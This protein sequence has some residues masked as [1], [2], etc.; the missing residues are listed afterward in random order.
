[1]KSFT[2]LWRY[3]TLSLVLIA[4]TSTSVLAQSRTISSLDVTTTD[5]YS[6][7]TT[8]DIHFDLNY[9]SPDSEWLVF[10]NMT[11]PSGVTVNS[12]S[13]ILGSSHHLNQNNIAG[14]VATWGDPSYGY[15]YGYLVAYDNPNS[16]T[17]NVTID[18]TFSGD[19]TINFYGHGD[20]WGGTPHD[21]SGQAVVAQAP[22]IGD[23]TGTVTSNGAPL[24]GATVDIENVAQ[25]T[26]DANGNYT[27]SGIAIG[28]TTVRAYMDGMNYAID[29][30][31]VLAGQTVTLDFNLSP[32]IMIIS[33]LSFTETLNPEEYLTD[34]QGIQNAGN[35]GL[36][37]TA[38]I[39]YPTTN[40]VKN[41][42]LPA[43]PDMTITTP[44]SQ[45]GELLTSPAT[46]SGSRVDCPSGTVFGNPA[47]NYTNAYT[48]DDGAGYQC[49]QS[50]SATD[51]FQTVTFYFV[52][53]PSVPATSDFNIDFYQAGSTP[54]AS[55][56]SYTA[57]VN[58]VNTGEIL[59]GSYP[60]YAFTVELPDVISTLDGW[61]SI[62][63]AA[64]SNTY[65]WVNT[66]TGNGS[67]MQGS[68]SLAEQLTVCLGAPASAQWLSLSQYEGYVPASGGSMSIGV[69]FDASG[70]TAGD[71][72]TA[73]I[74]YTANPNVSQTTVPVTMIIAGDPLI[75][76]DNL[77]ATLIDPVTGQVNLTWTF[78]PTMDPTFQ[79]FL[80]RRNGTPIANTT[81]TS[82]T[83]MLPT[84]GTYSYTVTAVYAEG[85][86]TPAGPVE[87]DWLIPQMCW[88]P[89]APYNAQWVETQEDVN[90]SISNCGQGVL[91]FSFPDYVT[92]KLLNDPTIKKNDVSP[93]AGFDNMAEPKKG[94]VDP[95]DGQG[96]PIVLGAGGPDT[97]GYEWIDSDET[98][99]PTFNWI[100][101]STIGNDEGL[102]GDDNYTT[103]SLPFAFPFYGNTYSSIK[104]STNGFL[105]FGN[106]ATAYSNSGIPNSSEPNN[107]ITA[108]WDDLNFTGAAKLFTY[109]DATN[110]YYV[111]EY[112]NVPKLGSSFVNTY[113][114]ILYPNGKIMFQY[115]SMTGTLNSATVGIENA[116]GSDGLQV[117]YNT[118]YIHDGLAVYIFTPDHFIVS[119]DPVT[120]QVSEGD[121]VNVTLTYSSVG[122]D[123]GD[124]TED[125]YCV[126]NELEP[127][128]EHMIGN[129]MH[130]YTPAT[131]YGTVTDCN[132]GAPMAGVD[133]TATGTTTYTATTDDNGYYEMNVD[134]DTYDVT[135]SLLGY[136]SATVSGVF[137]PEGVMTE[138]ST[139]MCEMPYPVSWVV[140]DPNQDDTQ[141]LVTWSLPMGPYEIIYDDGTAEEFVSWTAPGNAVAV[142][143][144]PAGYPATV[145]G[146]RL[147][148]GDGSFPA[149]ANFIG[150]QFAIG[151]LDDDGTN[152]MPGTVL[153]SI[154]VDVNNY[155]WVQFEGLNTTFTDGDF[156][157]VMWQLAN[158]PFAAPIG[159]DTQLPT[160]YRSYVKVGSNDWSVSPYQDFMMRAVVDGP[161]QGV[162]MSANA[163][164][165][166]IYPP[167]PNGYK[168]YIATGAPKGIPGM[169]KAGTFRPVV[170][171]ASTRDLSD[172]TV[173]YVNGFD[174]DAGQTPED[175]TINVITNTSNTSYNH[176]AWGGLPEGWYAYAVRANY[177]SGDHSDWT[178]SNVVGHLKDVAVT[179]TVQLCDGS[180]ASDATVTIVG[181]NYPYNTYTA[182]TDTTGIIV[183][184]S[185]IKG[186]YDLFVTK[187]GYQDFQ[188]MGRAIFA[189]YSEN[190]MLQKNAYPVR[191]LS[192]D[193][194]TSLATWDEPLITQL[195][196]QDFEDP[197]FP[198]DGWQ[199][200]TNG[201]GWFRTDDGG[202]ANFP[203][204]PGDGF[205]ACDNDDAAGTGPQSDGSMDYL[206]TP[207][208]DLRESDN[209]SLYF[210]QYFDGG[211]GELATVEY[212]LDD[213]ATWQPLQSMSPVTDWTP[214]TIDLS[215]FS[216]INGA[217]QIWFAFHAD[218]A[219]QWASGWAVDN[220]AV[221]NGAAPVTSYIVYLDDN[222]VIELP[223]DQLSYAFENLQ[224]GTTYTA[225][226]VATYGTFCAQSE[227]VYYT[228]TSSYLYPPR[229]LT[230]AYVYGTNEVPLLWNPPMT[231]DGI[232]MAASANY[233]K[234]GIGH[235]VINYGT[236]K[237]PLAVSRK[238]AH[239][240]I[241]S[242]SGS[243][244][245]GDV[246]SQFTPSGM[247]A[248]GICFDGTYLYATDPFGSS[249]NTIVQLNTDGS[250]TGYTIDANYGGS[251]IGDMSSDGTYIY[252]CNVGG[253]DA[254]KVIDIASGALV[255]T[256]TGDFATTSQ[257][258][259]AHDEI[260]D[261]FYIGGWNSNNIW[262]VD[263]TGATLDQHSESGVSGLAYHPQGGPNADGSLWVVDNAAS[264]PVNEYDINNGWTLLQNFTI[265]DGA[266]NSGAGLGLNGNGN[267]WLVNQSNNVVYEIETD[268]PLNGGSSS[269]VV[270]DGLISFNVYRDS[271][272]IANVPYNGESTDDTII[273]VDNNLMPGTYLYDVS[274][275]YDLS[276]FGFPG[277]TGE[278]AWE[279]TDTV[280]V[281]WGMNLPFFED[282]AQGNFDFNMWTTGSSNWGINSQVGN[283]APSAEFSWDPQLQNDYSS[284]LVSA[285]MNANMLSEGKIWL[286][287]DVKLDSRNNTGDEKLLIEVYD[288]QDWTQVAE[289][290]NAN[291][292]FGFADGHNHIDI[293]NHAMGRVF[294]VRFNAVGQNSFNIISWFVDNISIYRECAAPTDLTGEYHWENPIPDSNWGAKIHWNAPTL[295]LPV[296]GW[297]HWDDGTNASAV[298]L[299]DDGPFSVAARWDAGMLNDWNGQNFDGTYIT[300]MQFF[301]S[302]DG[303]TSIVAKIWTGADASTLIWSSDVTSSVVVGEWNEVTLDTPLQI[304]ASLEYWV[305]YT[306][307]GIGGKFP[308]GTDAGPAIAGYGDMVS[309]DGSTWNTLSGYNLDYNWNVEFYAE[310]MTTSTPAPAPVI[311]NTVYTA[312]GASLVQGAVKEHHIAAIR[313]SNRDFQG[314][315]NVYRKADGE[316]DYSLDTVIPYV[317]GQNAYTFYDRYPNVNSH[318]G[319]YYKVSTVYSSSIDSCEPFAYTPAPSIQDFVYVYVTDVNN[320]LA[321]ELTNV[322]PNPAKD[323]V[324]ITSSSAITHV[325]VVNYLG[326]VVYNKEV[327]N[328]T[329]LTLNTSSY[330]SGVYVVKIDTESGQ[331]T[332]RVTIAK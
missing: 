221:H 90:L 211:Y 35:G 146:G 224:Y 278:S 179:I 281:V 186:N 128:N 250:Q 257:R 135:F 223:P 4:A 293:T 44:L 298:G 76:A 212:S 192:V 309:L 150:S 84:Y 272:S 62:H 48:S 217:S 185:V 252:A 103:L 159:V 279:G 301:I 180:T 15:G 321:K 328:P 29:S 49:Y 69:N 176:T 326:Q 263:N 88:N 239:D 107:L 297:I 276:T 154:V 260:N 30:V 316:N 99:G 248:W 140:A 136:Q 53:L 51:N 101:I 203:I 280:N 112:Q 22:P 283:D 66:T 208:M 187:V 230:D 132:S 54:G 38:E 246:V 163:G 143:F 137:A 225:A 266:G 188:H 181:R 16:F 74:V 133:V 160:V 36:H 77:E 323:R 26:T 313:E 268:E 5:Q 165:K 322:Y 167:K 119:V 3:L 204:P 190:V 295:P 102:S 41:S 201:V 196:V 177:Q 98:G 82:Y 73:N 55:F 57:S 122:F 147:F 106:N 120:G 267:L 117:A 166:M 233:P 253:D 37:W 251:W 308:A 262:R 129:T 164:N 21:Y 241:V 273:Y 218:D 6:P 63:A 168:G 287:Y 149:G 78:A 58:G 96:H 291:G 14:S 13:N 215:S 271:D 244:D 227:K 289:L 240:V 11:F 315:F 64:S 86:T 123:P 25:T 85:E 182:I 200:F 171:D 300:K 65:Y 47:V 142:K 264:D 320:P 68:T 306:I 193:P 213:G 311:D 92:Q 89:N 104:A 258:G 75:P 292:S 324:T 209:F 134:E 42:T 247:Q 39:Q 330:E 108:F 305:G 87:V 141:C 8:M 45:D 20:S 110:N 56:A 81:N 243:R 172:Y 145:T 105:T 43:T 332:K 67:A 97:F 294:Q 126:T 327:N 139:S 158:P 17:V 207:K 156:Y 151:V 116:D 161:N 40:A 231:D 219:G 52:A 302:D 236:V 71:V 198:P 152:G 115:S 10:F 170:S 153:D 79:Y 277:Q 124:Y 282:W 199:S 118:N 195:V 304:D 210:D 7:G 261:E 242:T 24:Q 249:G 259:L 307:D 194:L 121:S 288:G 216:G 50:Y 237:D 206:I 184:D 83:D 228:W 299:T 148:V 157:L 173:A 238:S 114:Y 178:Y 229:N 2:R 197:L 28:M 1:M 285:P 189:D 325:M 255:N 94:E 275:L 130:V 274:A 33:P 284:A 72:Y 80:I 310:E 183:F 303:Y 286:D 31:E 235:T 314:Y 95:R 256:I 331:V 245:V 162:T 93:I 23:I 91:S 214:E 234:Y 109:Y 100:D 269:G 319:Y 27:L 127:N 18:A 175:G 202:S 32:P 60:I 61:V 296:Q 70:T 113:E 226:V 220:V 329:T 46:P 9:D 19:M 169:E 222:Y 174:P 205:Y 138:A 155:N 232:P 254:I 290:T 317:D 270:P 265:P 144:T 12:I 59:L 312:Q 125:L 111:I 191:N 131:L 34:Y 318:T